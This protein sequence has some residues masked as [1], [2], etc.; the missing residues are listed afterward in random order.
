MQRS[1][2]EARRSPYRRSWREAWEE[3]A[4]I[5]VTDGGLPRGRRSVWHGR[6]SSPRQ[7][8]DETA[9]TGATARGRTGSRG[10]KDPV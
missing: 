8:H 1:P 9:P 3:R 6:D 10:Q 2:R 4:A 7:R 5:M